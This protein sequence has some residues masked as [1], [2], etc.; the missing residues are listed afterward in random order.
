MKLA[1]NLYNFFCTVPTGQNYHCIYGKF[2][3]RKNSSTITNTLLCY[4]T[5]YKIDKIL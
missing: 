1:A 4:L 5:G 2:N 3:P